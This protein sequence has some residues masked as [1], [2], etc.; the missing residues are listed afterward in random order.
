MKKDPS[1]KTKRKLFSP[2]VSLCNGYL[3]AID[4]QHVVENLNCH[5]YIQRKFV[6]FNDRKQLLRQIATQFQNSRVRR[7][8]LIT[9]NPTNSPLEYE[10]LLLNF[11][12]GSFLLLWKI[13]WCLL[14]HFKATEEISFLSLMENSC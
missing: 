2:T 10:L 11:L 12:L 13:R 8:K 14:I 1:F 3:I 9:Q 7:A 6:P 5:H 4:L